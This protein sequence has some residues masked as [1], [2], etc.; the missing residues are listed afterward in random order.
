MAALCREIS[1]ADKPYDQCCTHLPAP[2]REG[3]AAGA[4]EAGIWIEAGQHVIGNFYG[5]HRKGGTRHG[6]SGGRGRAEGGGKWARTLN[7]SF[8]QSEM[9][10]AADR[11]TNT[12]RAGRPLSVEREFVTREG[13]A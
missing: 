4:S 12:F 11:G 6:R 2:P 9:E 7:A 10:I 3:E 8:S 1:K 13:N 5:L